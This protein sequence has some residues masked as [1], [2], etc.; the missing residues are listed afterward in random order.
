MSRGC[1]GSWVSGCLTLVDSRDQDAQDT[2]EGERREG[3]PTSP[4]R[5]EWTT[6]SMIRRKEER[7]RGTKTKKAERRP[8]PGR[9]TDASLVTWRAVLPQLFLPV[10]KTRAPQ[11]R[12]GLLQLFTVCGP[13]RSGPRE[14]EVEAGAG[15]AH[16][17]QEARGRGGGPGEVQGHLLPRHALPRDQ[18]AVH[19]ALC[20]LVH[21][22]D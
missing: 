2:A 14:A 22:L 10:T 3:E 15:S 11:G 13:C 19:S 18:P 6:K 17:S 20:R 7:K 9:D 5:T 8:D 1:P 21:F 12:G 4:W 16:G